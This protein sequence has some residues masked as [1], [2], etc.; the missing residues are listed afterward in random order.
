MPEFG[1]GRAALSQNGYVIDLES[2]LQG[3]IF[4]A[5][6]MHDSNRIWRN[7]Y[8]CFLKERTECNPLKAFYDLA[9]MSFA[10]KRKHLCALARVRDGEEIQ[11]FT[12]LEADLESSRRI[13]LELL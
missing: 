9:G 8:L 6:L 11:R 13:F 4:L 3:P 5:R 10:R 1:A 7:R 12:N 2:E